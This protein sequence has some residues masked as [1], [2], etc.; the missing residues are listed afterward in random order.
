MIAAC[1]K[2][3]TRFRLDES[4]MPSE[5]ARLRCSKCRTIFA[6]RRKAP[7]GAVKAPISVKPRVV[8]AHDDPS[9]CDMVEEV[10]RDHFE[11]TKVHDGV[12]AL[13][14]IERQRPQ[15]VILDVALPGMYGFEVCEHIKGHAS[16]KGT[17]V[18]LSAAIYDRT[19]Y[20]RNPVSLYGADDYIEKHHVHDELVPKI[21]RLLLSGMDAAPPGEPSKE[22]HEDAVT[23]EVTPPEPTEKDV[24]RLKAGEKAISPADTEVRAKARRLARIIVSD[25]ALYNEEAV[26]EGIKSGTFYKLLKDDI[27]EGIEH[28][29][30][31]TPPSVSAESCLKEAFEDFISKRKSEMGL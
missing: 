13:S 10:L 21:N 9:F 27:K 19:R 18:I 12:K 17:K 3:K 6:V 11:V 8:V 23:H 4:K 15:V 1:P 14:L 5:G 2:C 22:H 7:E 31:K 20:K 16:L 30:K 28:L 26:S 29:R 25:I 24:E